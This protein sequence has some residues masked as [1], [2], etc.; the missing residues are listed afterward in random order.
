MRANNIAGF[1]MLI[2]GMPNVGKSCLLNSLRQRGINGQK[3]A[4]TG[5]QP[6]VTRSLST[7]VKI[8]ELHEGKE[9][10]Y[11]LDTPGVFMPYVPN[12]EAMLKLALCGMVK[13][14]IISPVTLAD[15]LLYHL[16]LYWPIVY[17]KYHPPTNDIMQLLDAVARKTGRLQKGAVPDTEA[18]ALWLIQQ[19]RLGE[20]GKFIL[21][22]LTTDLSVA[23]IEGALESAQ[24][25]S[26]ARKEE[27][28]RRRERIMARGTKRQ[29]H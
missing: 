2:V 1:H 21:D 26:Q 13:D 12:A 29:T 14:T 10:I 19:W 27:K 3:A 15:Y 23:E 18:A 7:R 20:F 24:S 5:A 8:A 6:G 9:A 28:T 4:R 16:N 11:V 25:L 17:S 22:D